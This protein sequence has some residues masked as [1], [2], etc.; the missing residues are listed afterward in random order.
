[1]VFPASILGAL[2]V[3]GGPGG[4]LRGLGDEFALGGASRRD[5]SRPGSLGSRRGAGGRRR[6]LGRPHA[7]D[8]SAGAR[9]LHAARARDPEP[10]A[11][12]ERA[13]DLGRSTRPAPGCGRLVGK[14]RAP[15]GRAS[16]SRAHDAREH[17]GNR[18][19]ADLCARPPF[20]PPQL[21]GAVGYLSPHSLRVRDSGVL[22][23]VLHRPDGG[24]PERAD[25]AL[26]GKHRG[27]AGSDDPGAPSLRRGA[28]RGARGRA[29]PSGHPNPAG[30]R[31]RAPRAGRKRASRCREQARSSSSRWIASRTRW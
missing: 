16:R 17:H 21:G 9:L 12:P 29:R 5:R 1:M 25:P 13:P 20:R 2:P 22:L 11:D 10:P 15:P 6:C 19:T 18:V 27:H 3:A 8:R 14:T 23:R 24:Q 30:D 31:G 26:A 28:A 4:E 7:G